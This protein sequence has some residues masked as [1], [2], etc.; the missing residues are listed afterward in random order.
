MRI[1]AGQAG[2]L[3]LEVP[4]TVTRPTQD[5]VRQAVFSMIADRVA[6]AK[7]LDLFAGS[8][9]LGLEALSRGASSCLFVDQN[10]GAVEVIRRNL[11]K[12]RLEE[13]RVRG[14]DAFRFLKSAPGEAFDLVFA[15]PPYAHRPDDPDLTLRLARSEDLLRCLKPGGSAILEC[16]VTKQATPSWSPWELLRERDY[17]TTRILWL[18]KSDHAAA[19]DLPASV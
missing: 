2:G 15:D 7:V 5:R 13:G 17:G 19:S 12:A 1:I 18:Q 16:R 11:D 3:R 4:K 14:A 10:R 9:A 6:G 8:G